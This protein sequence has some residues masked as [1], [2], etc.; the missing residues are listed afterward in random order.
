[1]PLRLIQ[2]PHLDDPVSRGAALASASGGGLLAVASPT[3]LEAALSVAAAFLAPLVI[4][5]VNRWISERAEARSLRIALAAAQAAAAV[6]EAARRAA[7]ER[8]AALEAE[9]LPGR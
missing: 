4:S 2:F 5:A 9:G 6:A 7:E 8:L 3:P 1:V